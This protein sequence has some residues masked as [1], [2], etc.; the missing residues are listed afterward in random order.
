MAGLEALSRM[1]KSKNK[2]SPCMVV[3]DAIESVGGGGPSTRV[4]KLTGEVISHAA[5]KAVDY[6]A[7]NPVA[8]GALKRF[9]SMRKS[10]KIMTPKQI[11][12]LQSLL[13]DLVKRGVIRANSPD[14]DQEICN[15]IIKA[16]E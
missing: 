8:R 1:Q 11:G 9:G 5:K 12:Y 13:E 4:S 3:D 7:L 10:G 14:G 6:N 16:L 2:S 15:Q